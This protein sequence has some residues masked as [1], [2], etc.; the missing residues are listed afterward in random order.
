[1][2]VFGKDQGGTVALENFADTGEVH[3]R[4]HNQ[5]AAVIVKRS[6]PAMLQLADLV[7]QF[8]GTIGAG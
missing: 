6:V 8:P 3:V 5:S 2:C 7:L 1:M 4:I